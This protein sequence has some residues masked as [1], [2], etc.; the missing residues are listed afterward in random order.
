VF[1]VHTN[2]GVV[3]FTPTD[4][5]L[6]AINLRENPDA[7]FV[8]VNNADL[9]FSPSPVQTVRNKFKDFTKKQV[10]AAA[11][12]CR[13]MGMI[14]AP[15]KRE[16]QGLVRMNLLQDC[17]ISHTDIVNAN[18]I[19]GPD[20]ANIRGKTARR[21]LEH[22]HAEIVDIPQQILDIQKHV[23]LTADVMFV[24]SVPFLVSSS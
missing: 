23:T 14:G 15:S 11:T 18:K 12:A 7:A 4:K 19:Y 22:V 16:Y 5:G 24:N 2:T 6:H 8:L 1:K 9:A 17:P 10:Q 21:K 13:L 3:K 20:L